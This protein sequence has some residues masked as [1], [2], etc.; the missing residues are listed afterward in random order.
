MSALSGLQW[1]DWVVLAILL[2]ATLGG[3]MRGF[4][5]AACSLFGLMLG[6]VLACWHY[7]QF[8]GML[9]S[10]IHEEALANAVAFLILAAA[11]M[12]VFDVIGRILANLV[13]KMGLGCL[14]HLGGA[15]FGFVQGAAIVTVCILVTVAFFPQTAWLE[16]ARLPRRF[17]GACNALTNMG[18]RELGD[19][20]RASLLKLEIESKQMLKKGKKL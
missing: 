16:E 4:F 17:F 19:R 12:L 15:V 14:D 6:V 8:S 2:A 1:V 7:E 9:Q 11:V 18:P 3:F 13:R 5:R 10:V 20:V